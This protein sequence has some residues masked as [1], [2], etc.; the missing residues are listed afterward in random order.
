M[1]AH[2][3]DLLGTFGQLPQVDP[4]SMLD[5]AAR[6]MLTRTSYV[7]D[8]QE[9]DR[10]AGAIA[11]VLTRPDLT[12]QTSTSWL[13][14]VEADFDVVGRRSMMPVYVSNA[15]RTLRMLYLLADQGAPRIPFGPPHPVTHREAVKIRLAEVLALVFGHPPVKDFP[16]KG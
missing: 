7:Y 4:G 3:A 8:Q 15:M 1:V 9:D 5:L 12:V 16:I 11:R 14:V 10:L 6:R 13:D 2:G